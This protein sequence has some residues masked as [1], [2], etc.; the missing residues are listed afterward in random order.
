M[1][2]SKRRSVR[3]LSSRTELKTSGRSRRR[4]RGDK[5]RFNASFMGGSNAHLVKNRSK[6]KRSQNR[7]RG[8]TRS[9]EHAKKSKAYRPNLQT[10][11]EKLEIQEFEEYDKYFNEM[12]GENFEEFVRSK[13][14]E[15]FFAKD[16]SYSNFT[17]TMI[18]QSTMIDE[19]QTVNETL[20]PSQP[21]PPKGPAKRIV[22]IDG[23]N[24]AFGHGNS[25]VFSIEGLKICIE[26]FEALGHEV[27]AVIPQFR[28]KR[29][30]S[31]N[32]RLLEKLQTAGKIVSTPCKTIGYHGKSVSSYDDRFILEAAAQFDAVVISNDNYRD[33]MEEKVQYREVIESRV[34]G[35]TWFKD[36][37]MIP[38]DPYG[39]NGPKLHEILNK[40]V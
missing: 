24:V 8:R 36:M 31:S 4:R 7:S 26:Y 11:Q 33:L 27:K 17:S 12:E 20:V 40:N 18:A 2:E 3:H 10:I 15:S 6:N 5:S 38:H 34:V 32:Q 13:I 14:N 37:L 22:I 23:S 30:M 28:F 19:E 16:L 39:Q 35:F 1:R 21:E 29:A 9:V 25:S